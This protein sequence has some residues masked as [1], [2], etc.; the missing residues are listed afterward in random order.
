MTVRSSLRELNMEINVTGFANKQSKRFITEAVMFYMKRL[1]KRHLLKGF[2]I[3][4]SI[5][6][7]VDQGNEGYCE[8]IDWNAHNKPREF[9]IVVK[10]CESLRKTLMTIAHECVHVKQFAIGELSENQ[11]S[12]RGKHIKDDIEYWESPWEIE[13]FGRERGLYTLFCERYQYEFKKS[14]NERDE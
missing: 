11:S 10:K 14:D 8:I 7:N 1:V 3:N 4:V 13:A 12:W 6:K 9:L 2:I 5:R